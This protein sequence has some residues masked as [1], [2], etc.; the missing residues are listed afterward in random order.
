[1]KIESTRNTN[2]RQAGFS[3]VLPIHTLLFEQQYQINHKRN[4]V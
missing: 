2:Q 3:L 4:V 1:M